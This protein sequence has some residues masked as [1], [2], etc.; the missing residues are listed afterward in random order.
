MSGTVGTDLFTGCY[1]VKTTHVIAT[2]IHPDM[3]PEEHRELIMTELMHLAR[4]AGDIGS[5]RATNKLQR[6][7]KALLNIQECNHH[8]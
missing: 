7:L 3:I 2:K 5:Q 1:V 6:E 8:G 4:I